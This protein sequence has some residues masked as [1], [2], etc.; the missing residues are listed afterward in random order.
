MCFAR[1]F[2]V[3]DD[4]RGKAARLHLG[5]KVVGQP[6]LDLT[7]A[8]ERNGRKRASIGIGGRH[9]GIGGEGWGRKRRG[10]GVK[11]VVP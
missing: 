11:V 9:C 8:I 7:T 4:A 1:A 3:Y 10:G 6:E 2:V 5:R